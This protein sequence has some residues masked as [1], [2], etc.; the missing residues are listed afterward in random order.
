MQRIQPAVV[1]LFAGPVAADKPAG[2]ASVA[3]DPLVV[4]RPRASVSSPVVAARALVSG[5]LLAGRNFVE[6]WLVERRLAG[7]HPPDSYAA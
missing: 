7:R 2:C 1:Q 3:P 6:R 5:R 4:E